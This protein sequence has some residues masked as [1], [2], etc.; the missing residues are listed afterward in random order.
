MPKPPSAQQKRVAR[1]RAVKAK[2]RQLRLDDDTYRTML[3]NLTGKTSSVDLDLVELNRVLD[4]LT[5]LGARSPSRP[6]RPAA[7]VSPLV[8]KVEAQCKAMD[9]P[10]TYAL[11]T[12][13]RQTGREIRALAWLD[14][15]ELAAVVA[16]LDRHQ[17]KH[18]PET[19]R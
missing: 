5:K 7:A 1:I 10:V 18:F 14:A 13:S 9:L 17:R 4:H 15:T 6:V 2:V 11:A 19:V 8:G 3:H 12:A 16:A